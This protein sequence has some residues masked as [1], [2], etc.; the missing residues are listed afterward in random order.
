MA[1]YSDTVGS[2]PG[3]PYGDGV[4]E[5]PCSSCGAPPG[6]RCT[7]EPSVQTVEGWRPQKRF[8]HHPCVARIT[9]MVS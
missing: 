9:G 1:D 4:L 6:I 5:R 2:L 3:G 8:R 7:F